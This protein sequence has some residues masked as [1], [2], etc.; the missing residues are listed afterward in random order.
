MQFDPASIAALI[1]AASFAAGLNVYATLATLGLLARFNWVAL[2][3]GLEVLT[4]T[5]ILVACIL[6]FAAEFVADKIP[7]LDLIWSGLHTAV[8][9]PVAALIAYRATMNLPPEMQVL[10]AIA[11]A[12][13]A[14]ASHGSKT[15]VRAAVTPSP[16]PI[17][18]IA[19]ST[20]E[21]FMAIG[22]TWLAT[23]HPFIAATIAAILTL[24]AV[25]A[26]R[27]LVRLARRML[28]KAA[29][30]RPTAERPSSQ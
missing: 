3:P 7:G 20:G 11:G 12:L 18:N 28:P 19:L 1:V 16:E 29:P 25:L 21:D 24:I 10:A 8:R 2:P 23:R 26:M 4:H 17:S 9:I 30:T 15:A 22:V 14:L 27:W 5:W 6:L 13:I